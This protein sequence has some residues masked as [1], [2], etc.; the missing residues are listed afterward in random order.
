MS[1]AD[2]NLN[3]CT[4]GQRRILTIGNDFN[5]IKNATIDSSINNSI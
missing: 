4:L 3:I 1:D 2:K 5:E